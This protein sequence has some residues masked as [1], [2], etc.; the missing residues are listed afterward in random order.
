[1]KINLSSIL[2]YIVG[3]FGDNRIIMEV[4]HFVKT[5]KNCNNSDTWEWV[6]PQYDR[7][8]GHACGLTRLPTVEYLDDIYHHQ[9]KIYCSNPKNCSDAS[10]DP[11]K[12]VF[13]VKPDCESNLVQ[14]VLSNWQDDAVFAKHFIQV[15]QIVYIWTFV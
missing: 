5:V 6:L 15:G 3:L 9:Q 14:P 12:S 7:I 8:P 13:N 10:C 11:Y 4:L 2:Q 1:M